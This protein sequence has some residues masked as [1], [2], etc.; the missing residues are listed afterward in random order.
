MFVGPVSTNVFVHVNVYLIHCVSM[1]VI[2]GHHVMRVF[3]G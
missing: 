2:L 3:Q 1:F